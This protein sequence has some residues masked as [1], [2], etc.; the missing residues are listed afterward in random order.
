MKKTKNKWNTIKCGRCGESH[1]N[2]TGKLD[3]NNIEYVICENTHKRMNVSG[4]GKEGNS[5]MFPTEWNTNDDII[6]T[7]SKNLKLFE[8]R[9]L[10]GEIK[11]GI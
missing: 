1:N 8:Q 5:F 4:T 6:K 3:S 11:L 2:Y 10:N 9:I 7:W